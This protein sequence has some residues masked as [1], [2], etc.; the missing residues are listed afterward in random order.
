MVNLVLMDPEFIAA[1][2]RLADAHALLAA[3]VCRIADQLTHR[4]DA[5]PEIVPTAIDYL[6]QAVGG[7]GGDIAAAI[8]EARRQ[9]GAGSE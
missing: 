2:N 6:A 5:A 3:N 9:D 4:E 1:L 8:E 7:I